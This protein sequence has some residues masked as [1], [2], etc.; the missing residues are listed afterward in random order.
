MS[1]AL[2][3]AVAVISCEKSEKPLIENDGYSKGTFVINEGSYNAN[4][5]SISFVYPD[6]NVI[7]NNIFEAT[8]GR[9]L[10]DIVQSFAIGGDS[11]GIIVVNNSS[12]VEIVSLKTFRSKAEPIPVEYPRYF[13]QVDPQKGY[14]SGG[15]FQGYLYVI[16]LISFEITD[17][18]AVGSGPENLLVK[19][20]RA[21]VANSGGWGS[22]ST[23]SVVDVINDRVVDTFYVGKIPV[24]MSWDSES[25]IWVY[26]KG[27]TNYVDIETDAS[28]QKIDPATGAVLWQ[29]K[30]GTA[31][32][33]MSTPARCAAS[34]DGSVIF[35]IRPDGIYAINAATPALQNEPVIPGNFYGLD[36]NPASGNIYVFESSFTGN[37]KMKIYTVTGTLIAEGTVGIGPNG[38]AFNF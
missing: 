24:D 3:L 22:D 16:D 38:A 1:F 25:K 17:S 20:N 37:G 34:K 36:V 2:M 12:K 31:L 9:P 5:G 33:Y 4:N 10:G 6:S 14:L 21:F 18:I 23:L 8:N 15:K 7:V 30:V 11:L 26:C 29:S 28:L 19:N 32:D 13:I 27:Y 35:Y